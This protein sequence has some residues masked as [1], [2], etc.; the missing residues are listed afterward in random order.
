MKNDD[1]KKPSDKD[2]TKTNLKDLPEEII[3]S[4]IASSVRLSDAS[5]LSRV[6]IDFKQQLDPWLL[7]RRR[8]E[9]N[10]IRPL[11]GR[12][13]IPMP[14]D[15]TPDPV[16]RSLI[17]SA[18]KV[19]AQIKIIEEND[20]R[21]LF[22]HNNLEYLFYTQL[23]VE[24]IRE[25]SLD[26]AL[27]YCNND[28]ASWL[29]RPG[30]KFIFKFSVITLEYAAMSGN[31]E[32]V[33]WLMDAERGDDRVRLNQH[34][35]EIAAESGNLEL[36]KWLMR[37]WPHV[38]SHNITSFAARSGNLELVKWL[39]DAEKR[40]LELKHYEYDERTL[41]NA[42]KSGNLELV[43]W[44]MRVW[45]YSDTSPLIIDFAA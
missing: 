10:V 3:T 20:K 16:E 4:K 22:Q 12:Y 26:L 45:P 25:N 24:N 39:M 19:E 41:K 1:G 9:Y 7:Q 11:L 17:K 33:K 37:F 38:P 34:T 44:L 43:K 15:T 29:I 30:N 42:V 6:S 18:S 8:Q 21:L 32:L 28:L 31:I 14:L 36:V 2:T 13:G 40:G 35:L 27:Q 5:S 23:P